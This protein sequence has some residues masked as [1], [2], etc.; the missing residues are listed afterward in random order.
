M[1]FFSGYVYTLDSDRELQLTFGIAVTKL[2][3][4]FR[5]CYKNR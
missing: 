2:M 3:E 5:N 1:T 4:L